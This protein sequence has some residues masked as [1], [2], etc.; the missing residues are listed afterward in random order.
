[1]GNRLCRQEWNFSAD[2]PIEVVKGQQ[3]TLEI[4]DHDDPGQFLIYIFCLVIPIL[5]PTHTSLAESC[6]K[7]S[8]PECHVI[9]KYALQ[10]NIVKGVS[11]TKVSH[12]FP[13]IC[14]R[15][16]TLNHIQSFQNFF[17]DESTC[18]PR[19]RWFFHAQSNETG[20]KVHGFLFSV[21]RWNKNI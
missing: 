15:F 9:P 3:L 8:K 18:F 13:V 11:G 5:V 1:M 14:P 12:M 17:F 21:V 16:D 19:L 10:Q 2:F 7:M 20:Q 4:F 6:Q